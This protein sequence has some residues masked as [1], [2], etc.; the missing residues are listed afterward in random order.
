MLPSSWHPSLTHRRDFIFEFWMPFCE[1]VG[2]PL[3][4]TWHFPPREAGSLGDYAEIL[5]SFS[6]IRETNYFW[7]CLHPLCPFL[8]EEEGEAIVHP[9][10]WHTDSACTGLLFHKDAE[11]CKQESET[12]VSKYNPALSLVLLT[13]SG[14]DFSVLLCCSLRR[15]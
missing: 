10:S 15:G 12:F 3:A 7:R 8:L 4:E 13:L 6:K 1:W 14:W 2:S 5:M 11:L 9:Q